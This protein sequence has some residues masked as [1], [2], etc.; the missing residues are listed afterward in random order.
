MQ[1]NV[2]KLEVWN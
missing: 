1:N 2:E